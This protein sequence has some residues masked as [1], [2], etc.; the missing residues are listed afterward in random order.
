MRSTAELMEAYALMQCWRH[1]NVLTEA[2]SL[3]IGLPP[4][5]DYSVPKGAWRGA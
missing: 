5:A 1:A 2:K 4:D 3:H